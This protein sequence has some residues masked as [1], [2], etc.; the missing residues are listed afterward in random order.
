MSEA[1]DSAIENIRAL[2]DY[3]KKRLGERGERAVK[4][5]QNDIESL[6]KLK[7]QSP[8]TAPKDGQP[9]LANIG[10]PWA[11]MCMFSLA[12]NNWV[13]ASVQVNMLQG[14]YSDPYF[15]NEWAELKELKAWMPLPELQS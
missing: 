2:V 1:I 10:F 8:E 4:I 12:N 15:E 3:E 6:E 11:M 13:Y 7:W 14:E 9:F 5:L